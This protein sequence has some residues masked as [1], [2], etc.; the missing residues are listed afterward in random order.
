VYTEQVDDGMGWLY[1]YSDAATIEATGKRLR[2]NATQLRGLDGETRT[3]TQIEADIA[4][5]LL[6]GK[7][8]P[9]AVTVRLGVT[10][11]VTAFTTQPE[12][13]QN[14]R[15][16]P[17][18]LDGYGPID[19]ATATTLAASATSFRRIFTD[20]ING[21]MLTMDRKTYRPTTAQR[22]FLNLKFRTC[23][24]PGCNR[25]ADECDIDHTKDWQYNGPTNDNNLAPMHQGHHSVKHATKITATRNRHGGITWTTP[26]GYSKDTD[27]PPF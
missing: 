26:T 16:D 20:P 12:L 17:A 11:P 8:T 21:I 10:I 13:L 5:D 15:T 6:T 7:G 14:A 24:A 27:P 23:S 4:G 22:E 3:L 9:Y 1:L 19:P 25:P 18:I 2:A